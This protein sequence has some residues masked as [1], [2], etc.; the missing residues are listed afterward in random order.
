MAR[1]SWVTRSLTNPSSGHYGGF[2]H[3]FFLD[4]REVRST[5]SGNASKGQ[6]ATSLLTIRSEA[7]GSETP[8]LISNG[9]RYEPRVKAWLAPF[10][11]LF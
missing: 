1:E 9:S 3:S 8:Q 11:G 2:F 6:G 10:G 7:P 5:S 4:R